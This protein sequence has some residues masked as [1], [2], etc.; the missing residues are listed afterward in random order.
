MLCDSGVG[1]LSICPPLLSYLPNAHVTYLADFE[2]FP[3]GTRSEASLRNRVLALIEPLME[4]VQ[5]DVLVV[6]CNTAST[7]LL[8]ELRAVLHIPIVGVVPAIKP[9]ATLSETKSIGLLATP[10]TISRPYID[11]LITDFASD[12]QVVKLGSSRLVELAEN[13][14]FGQAI[15]EVELKQIIR[16][17]WENSSTPVD[18]IVL[19]CT[20][21]PL[22][23]N[24]LQQASQTFVEQG[25]IWQDSGDAIARRVSSLL[26]SNSTSTIAPIL[27]VRPHQFLYT[28]K[29]IAT[30]RIETALLRIGLKGFKTKRLIA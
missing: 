18:V 16:P 26:K 14:L 21:F 30:N 2:G 12:C 1:G 13:W 24:N 17:F 7:L 20:H 10:A 28:G 27:E 8:P 5:P 15:N 29:E 11:Q 25:L 4:Q 3:Y 19:G 23:I 6:A 22:I 9:A